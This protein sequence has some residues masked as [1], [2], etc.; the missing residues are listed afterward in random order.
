MSSIIVLASDTPHRRFFI[1]SLMSKFSNIKC[2]IFETESIKPSF[3][4]GPFYEREERKFENDSFFVDFDD[5]FDDDLDK[6]QIHYVDTINS[7]QSIS[8]I[9]KISPSFAVIFGTRKVSKKVTKLFKDGAINVHRG[10][11]S[12]YRGLDSNLW[13]IYHEDFNNL[14]ITIHKVNDVLDTGEIIYEE[15]LNVPFNSEI[16]QLRYYETLLATNLTMR[17]IEDYNSGRIV[18]F[19]QEKFG[20]YY[21]FMPLVLKETIT[22]KFDIKY[23]N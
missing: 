5:D 15:K 9:T 4:T 1:K 10:I 3:S 20:R 19:K 2:V 14:G 18:S 16:F 13:A 7:E 17:A 22:K 11:A 12:E 8:L 21:S 23:K 6:V